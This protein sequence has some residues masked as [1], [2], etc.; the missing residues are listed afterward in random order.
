MNNITIGKISEYRY[1]LASQLM[2]RYQLL[3][4]LVSFRRDIIQHIAK[5]QS[6]GI[7]LKVKINDE[8]R[9]I[10]GYSTILIEDLNKLVK[11][12]ILNVDLRSEIYN[13]YGVDAY[14]IGYYILPIVKKSKIN[15][16]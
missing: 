8:Y 10:S 5:E 13:Q 12:W 16:H 3:R 1:E 14:V 2:T 6:I 7:Q 11:M 4:A 9:S 15:I